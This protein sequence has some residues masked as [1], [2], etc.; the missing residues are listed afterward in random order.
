MG[1]TLKVC[2]LSGYEEMEPDGLT[3]KSHPWNDLK[4]D[5]PRTLFIL[6]MW[7]WSLRA[8]QKDSRETIWRQMVPGQSRNI[9]I[10]MFAWKRKG[11]WTH[12]TRRMVRTL[13]C[14]VEVSVFMFLAGKTMSIIWS[15]VWKTILHVA[16]SYLV[17]QY[18][19]FKFSRFLKSEINKKMRL[20]LK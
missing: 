3:S 2:A 19:P 1:D 10:S 12:W 8:K 15:N 17:E 4:T 6:S 5:G 18:F 20:N 9:S 13:V 14:E 7:R 11:T 16:Y